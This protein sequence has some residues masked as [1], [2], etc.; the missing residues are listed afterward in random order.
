MEE[1]RGMH[2]DAFL[3][4]RIAGYDAQDDKTNLYVSFLEWLVS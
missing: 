2:V 3:W 1:R 4:V